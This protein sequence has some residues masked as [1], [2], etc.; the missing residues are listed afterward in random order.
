M[1]IP[2]SPESGSIEATRPAS[3]FPPFTSIPL[4]PESGSIEAFS[5]GGV[6]LDSGAFHSLRRVA[7]LKHEDGNC[8]LS[9]EHRIPLSPESGSIEAGDLRV[10]GDAGFYIPLSPESGS[11]EAEKLL[12]LT[13]RCSGHIPLSP[14]SGSIEASGRKHRSLHRRNHSTLSGEWLH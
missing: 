14:E 6:V 7:P 5:Y 4:S 8:R 2:L 13:S 3:R 9:H 11:I 12:G 10:S 1:L